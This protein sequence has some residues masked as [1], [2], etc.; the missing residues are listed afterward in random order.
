MACWKLLNAF[1][2]LIFFLCGTQ[3]SQDVLVNT[4]CST[5]FNACFKTCFKTSEFQ[6]RF[7]NI[8]LPSFLL[9]HSLLCPAV[10]AMLTVKRQ[11]ADPSLGVGD[12][13][14]VLRA[15]MASKASWDLWKYLQHPQSNATFNWKT[16]PHPG[17][18]AQTADLMY[19]FCSIA[20]NGI[21][22]G[23]K[24]RQAIL[25]LGH[26]RKIN[27]SKYNEDEFSDRCDFKIRVLLSHFRCVKQKA[28]EYTRCMKKSI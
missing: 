10:L 25:K 21:L 16:S 14:K 28:E 13:M 11:V 15:E 23:S 27:W 7:Q 18:M 8:L 6:G 2:W 4:C 12:M 24:L 9:F 26:E 1:L 3:G 5:F 19:R 20:P 22:Q 17:Y